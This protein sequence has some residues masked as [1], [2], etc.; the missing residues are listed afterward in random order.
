MKATIVGVVLFDDWF[1]AISTAPDRG[2]EITQFSFPKSIP[3]TEAISE[4]ARA[5]S[6][7]E[8]EFSA[9]PAVFSDLRDRRIETENG[10]TLN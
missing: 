2:R 3:I 8:G 7:F 9:G 6:K 5:R 4:N 1:K 10:R